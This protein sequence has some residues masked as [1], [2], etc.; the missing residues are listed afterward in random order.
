MG[1][2]PHPPVNPEK[3]EAPVFDPKDPAYRWK[4]SIKRA[5]HE[6]SFRYYYWRRILG[7]CGILMAVGWILAITAVWANL[8]FRRSFAE[9]QYADLALPWR[10]GRYMTAM[11]G[12][13]V[14]MGNAA[15]EHGAPDSA[16]YFYNAALAMRPN[17]AEAHR[18]ATLAQY[19][20]GL[21]PAA[22]SSLLAGVPAAAAADDEAYLRQFYGMAFETQADAEVEQ[23]S[24]SLLPVQPDQK[25]VH[26]LIAFQLAT[27]RFN[28][29]HYEE[30]EKLLTDWKLRSFPEGALLYAECQWES[31]R[32]DAAIQTLQDALSAFSQRDGI[33]VALEQMARAQN[34]PEA[35][36][37]YALL[38]QLADPEHFGPQLDVLYARHR[39]GQTAAE[40]RAVEAYAKAFKS[41]P[42]ALSQ[43][44]QFA[45]DTGQPK[46]AEYARELAQAAGQATAGFDLGTTEAGLAGRDY[47]A[48]AKALAR[49]K[50]DKAPTN[51]TF[52]AT[53]DGLDMVAKFGAGDSGAG[54]AFGN[55]LGRASALRPAEGVLLAQY[56]RDEGQA[57]PSRQLLERVYSANP[58]S[59]PALTDLVRAEI[60]AG[61][62]VKLRDHLPPLLK[63]RKVPR[64][65]LKGS[66]P[67]L[68]QPQDAA[69]RTKVAAQLEHSSALYL[70]NKR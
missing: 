60:L 3:L 56:L 68:T 40:Q 34:Q 24:R 11:S 47:A 9:I 1:Q 13:Y 36:L 8:K 33:Y 17:N 54:L 66:L 65:I 57:E 2:V 67:L 18:M 26:L 29:G 63:M 20:M 7:L 23:V 19:R 42:A 50:S 51:R 5:S 53:V 61:D 70:S 4:L 21:K 44:L 22:L 49:I 14:A 48:A 69:L 37:Q 12:H 39:L 52:E 62:R 32:T 15:L 10:W 64:D 41:D 46:I 28:R 38:R 55:F 25:R 16:F 35:V 30:A 59:E 43:L 45:V 27:A 31:G 58:D 6:G